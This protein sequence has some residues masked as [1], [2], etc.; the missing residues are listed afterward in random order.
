M[1][2][3]ANFVKFLS[4]VRA[5]SFPERRDLAIKIDMLG[6]LPIPIFLQQIEGRIMN[7]YYDSSTGALNDDAMEAL[8]NSLG[9]DSII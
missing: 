5:E 3:R 9:L 2:K 1:A 6:Q 7:R 4:E 8:A